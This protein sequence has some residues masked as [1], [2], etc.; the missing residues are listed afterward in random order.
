MQ[1]PR[2]AAV[3]VMAMGMVA[4]GYGIVNQRA[5]MQAHS[6]QNAR[7]KV[8]SARPVDPDRGSMDLSTRM[9]TIVL[10]PHEALGRTIHVRGDW[11]NEGSGQQA[12]P[13]QDLAYALCTLRPGDRLIVW[14][15]RYDGPIEIGEG[16]SDGTPERP[17]EL[18]MA[19]GA[20]FFGVEGLESPVDTPLLNVNRSYWHFYELELEPHWMRPTMRIS[21]DNTGI[22]IVGAHM[23]KGVGHGVEIQDGVSH[24][25]ITAAHMH[26]LGTLRGT[27]RDF[28]DPASAGVAISATAS[29]ILLEGLVMHHMEGSPVRALNPD[30]TP[31]SV[32]VLAARGI[33]VGAI[34]TSAMGGQ[35]D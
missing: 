18:V 23:L 2:A 21:A 22:K 33:R 19:S 8:H 34:S 14:P 31:A 24:V 29:D 4:I 30:G 10:P 15:G 11:P 1:I 6:E 26:H 28:R 13:Y 20:L 17:I 35:W 5:T 27:Q 16:C 7:I 9:P 32:E 25:S 3:I 12:N